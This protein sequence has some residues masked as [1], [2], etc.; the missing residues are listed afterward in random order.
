MMRRFVAMMIGVAL[1]APWL[2]P[3]PPPQPRWTREEQEVLDL[4]ARSHGTAWAEGHAHLIL[5]QAR[6]LGEL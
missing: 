4:V 3:L 5:G 6:A 1:A 2:R